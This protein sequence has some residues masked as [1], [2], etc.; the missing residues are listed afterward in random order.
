MSPVAASSSSKEKW[1]EIGRWRE[2]DG[3][4][5]K[6][7]EDRGRWGKVVG[8]RSFELPSATPSP[9]NPNAVDGLV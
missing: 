7:D 9:R 1:C 3:G 5:G 4:E 6:R 2:R 8:V